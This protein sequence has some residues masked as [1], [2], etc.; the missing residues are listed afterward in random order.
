MKV[1]D[2]IRIVLVQPI[3]MLYQRY[4]KSSKTLSTLAMASLSGWIRR[5]HG[6]KLCWIHLQT[7]RHSWQVVHLHVLDLDHHRGQP[8]VPLVGQGLAKSAQ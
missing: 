5:K 3:K 6:M 1:Q 4:W 2:T 8:V 7:G